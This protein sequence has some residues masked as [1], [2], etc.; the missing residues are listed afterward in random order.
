MQATSVHYLKRILAGRWLV[1]LGAMG[2]VVPAT[3]GSA[4]VPPQQIAHGPSQ[5]HV[6]W[7]FLRAVLRADYPA[8]YGRL[9]P[10]VRRAISQN[11]FE[12]AAQPLWKTG[13]RRNPEIQLYKLGVRLG[14][15]GFSQLFYSFSFEADSGLAKPPVLL[16]VTFRDTASRVVLGFSMHHFGSPI[17]P[18]AS[19]G[20]PRSK[21]PVK[22]G[23]RQKTTPKRA[24][25][26]THK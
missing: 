23:A 17:R 6:A 22:G 4:A 9:A 2:L 3:A 10:E 13:Q 21:L 20:G 12:S 14:E 8:A 7:Q 16:E 25:P 24:A 11:M 5:G 1:L 26:F 18:A 19:K 15:R